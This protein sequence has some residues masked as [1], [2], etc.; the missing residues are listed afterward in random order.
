MHSVAAFKASKIK[1]SSIDL[2]FAITKMAT[3]TI[4]I[5]TAQHEFS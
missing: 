1:S 5:T 2:S 4:T 3:T